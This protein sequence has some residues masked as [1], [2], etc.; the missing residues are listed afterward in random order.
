MWCPSKKKCTAYGSIP[1]EGI[2][3]KP[4]VQPPQMICPIGGALQ[5][6]CPSKKKCTAVSKCPES[7]CVGVDAKGCNACDGEL[8]CE[9][10]G[11]CQYGS[12]PCFPKP[13]TTPKPLPILDPM[14]FATG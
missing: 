14:C 7:E 12:I 8:F 5:M 6:W 1:C 2:G 11:E 9:S 10:A 13:G 4:V 3:P